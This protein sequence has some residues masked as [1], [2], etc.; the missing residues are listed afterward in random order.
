[1]TNL[2]RWFGNDDGGVKRKRSTRATRFKSFLTESDDDQ[3]AHLES[4][5]QKQQEVVRE[6]NERNDLLLR[7]DEMRRR[8]SLVTRR[9][10]ERTLLVVPF[11]KI[12]SPLVDMLL[13]ANSNAKATFPESVDDAVDRLKKQPYDMVYVVLDTVREGHK[14]CFFST[15]HPKDAGLREESPDVSKYVDLIREHAGEAE[16]IVVCGARQDQCPV[17]PRVFDGKQK[18]SA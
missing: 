15:D 18:E 4:L 13:A 1:M 12:K 10:K 17:A 7:A 6:L 8:I 9:N 16:I 5:K 3:I 14:S 2:F 11:S